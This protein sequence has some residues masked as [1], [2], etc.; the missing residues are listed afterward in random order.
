MTVRGSITAA[1]RGVAARSGALRR[2]RDAYRS[3]RFHRFLAAN[4]IVNLPIERFNDALGTDFVGLPWAMFAFG[5]ARGRSYISTRCHDDRIRLFLEFWRDHVHGGVAAASYAFAAC[6]RDGYRERIAADPAA[7]VRLFRPGPDELA[8]HGE[9]ACGVNEIPI[10]HAGRTVL[11]FCKQVNDPTA[12]CVPDAHYIASR[13]HAAL[14]ARVDAHSVPWERRTAVAVFRGTMDYGEPTNFIAPRTDL[15]HR[16]FLL[17]HVRDHGLEPLVDVAATPLPLERMLG[18]RY[19]LD[20]DGF[21]NTWDAL[22]WKL[23]SGSVVIKHRSIWKQW[24][25]DDLVPGVHYVPVENDFRDLE[26]AVRWCLEHDDECRMIGENAR[27]FVQEKLG[28]ETTCRGTVRTINDCLG[29]GPG[30][31]DPS[32]TPA[33]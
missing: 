30:G 9:L 5:H 17:R 2:L 19:L 23:Y 1:L 16:R 21:T 12:V 26:Q 4:G 32:R 8:A 13:G 20:V 3:H 18:H 10:L 22:F 33:A 24:F 27:R 31:R 25:Y 28:W 6:C 15:N 7:P 14:A 11:A 29:A